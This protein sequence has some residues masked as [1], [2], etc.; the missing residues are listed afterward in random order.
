MEP[1]RTYR[2]IYHDS[3]GRRHTE[4]GTF[5]KAGLGVHLE[6]LEEG[7]CLIMIVVTAFGT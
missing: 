7:G 5:T 2:I 4:Y 1:M 3:D 6:E